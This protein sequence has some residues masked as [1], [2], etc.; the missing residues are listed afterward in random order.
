MDSTRAVTRVVAEF[1]TTWLDGPRSSVCVG[2]SG[3]AD[4][5]ALTATAVGAGLDVTALV[6]DHGLQK[7]SAGVAA[8]AAETARGLGADA[9]VLEVRVGTRGGLEAAARDARYAAL[10]AA[11][12]G[13][14][15]LLAHTA[16][17]QAETVLLGLARGSG[18]RSIAGMR[19]WKAPWGR[20]LLQVRRM[21]TLAVCTEL[22]LAMHHDPHNRDP[23]FTRVRLRAEVI[24][25]LDD[26]LRGGVVDALVRTADGLQDDNDALDGWAET[27]WGSA[28]TLGGLEIAP[29][30]DLPRAVR[31]RV[32]RRWL[33]DIGATE[34]THRVI[35]A[36]D[37]LVV[38]PAAGGAQVAIGGDP[39]VRTV[40]ERVDEKLTVRLTE[41]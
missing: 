25:L 39:G 6:V 16:D 1:A 9:R 33:L 13:R 28:A 15:V 8:R 36:V 37:R 30:H 35:G 3:G 38:G 31:T 14:P 4:S 12:E 41:R 24:P 18:A 17:D 7:G 26:V 11:R 27:V 40:V 23:R 10:D 34:P 29:L 22:G 20:P 19:A 2:L 21:Q 32:I 5:L